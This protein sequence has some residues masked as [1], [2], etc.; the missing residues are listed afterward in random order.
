VGAA[1][2]EGGLCRGSG[3]ADRPT[4]PDKS[5]ALLAR[6]RPFFWPFSATASCWPCPTVCLSAEWSAAVALFVERLKGRQQ[7]QWLKGAAAAAVLACMAFVSRSW[8]YPLLL[9]RLWV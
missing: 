7:R 4:R 8:E 6:R 2:E 1:V 9:K 5:G 3:D